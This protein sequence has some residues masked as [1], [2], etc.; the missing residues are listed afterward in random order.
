[1][2]Y[3]SSKISI[4]GAGPTGCMTAIGL[5]KYSSQI[6]IYDPQSYE[7][8]LDRSRAY[9]LT[10]SSR[11]LFESLDLW[12]ELSCYLSPFE[13]LVVEDTEANKNIPFNLKDLSKENRKSEAIGWILDHRHLM[14]ILLG[15]IQK[16]AFIN[17]VFGESNISPI[18]E[19]ELV[20]AS[21]GA[22]SS[23]RNYLNIKTIGGSY[24]QGCLT[25]KVLIRGAEPL[26]AYE[27]FRSEGPLAILPMGGNI[28]QVV[29]TKEF[30]RCVELSKVP[31]SIFLDRL[32]ALLPIGLE[33]DALIDKP[34]AFPLQFSLAKRLYKDL[35]VLVGESAH[36]FHPV[37]GQG[38]NLGWRDVQALISLI[39]RVDNGSL[40]LPMAIKLYSW[41]R[42]LDHILVGAFTHFLVKFFSNNSKVTLFFRSPF[43]TLF[44]S[45]H[46]IRR[47]LLR[48]MTDG[49]MSIFKIYYN[50]NH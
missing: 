8:L 21:D 43:F 6:T 33:P 23:I 22:S 42:R 16:I 47:L 27:L 17:T 15:R 30:S 20:V 13:E 10:H 14:S 7:Q 37:G 34:S 44:K 26:I 48:I 31:S 9:A 32:S 36:C 11:R 19:N 2:I 29:W 45:I 40:S 18:K 28:F 24:L 25:A 1:M 50:I 49:P 3:N 46:W 5:A 38:L 35:V 4:Y 41:E 12:D 39:K